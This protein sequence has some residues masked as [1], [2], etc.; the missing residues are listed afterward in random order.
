MN[1]NN[2]HAT[3]PLSMSAGI[4]TVR[5]YHLP[6]TL[7]ECNLKDEF[8][9]MFPRIG[10][11][12]CNLF[13]GETLCCKFLNYTEEQFYSNR[14]YITG[15]LSK[16]PLSF[17]MNNC[18]KGYA[19][20]I[21]PVVGYHLLKTPMTEL[22]DRQVMVSNVLDIEGHLLQ[23]LEKNE[24]IGSIDNKYL[25]RFLWESLPDKK[26][27]LNDPIYHAVNYIITNKGKVVI[28]KLAENFCV[29]QR[30]LQ[31]QFL[32]KVGLTPK[33]YANIWMTQH[34]IQLIG[35]HPTMSLAEVAFRV[36][37]YDVAHLA[38]D[39]KD[40]VALPPSTLAKQLNPLT[41][42]YLNAPEITE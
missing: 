24:N 40:R 9:N 7:I 28:K 33:A 5:E 8:L 36:G 3:F 15:L 1:G 27:F 21:H 17:S 37:Y 19:F 20:K 30:T 23:W 34:A 2:V 25:N 22:V 4:K 35:K 29:S 6:Y 11:L 12:V 42:S 10:H 13:I 26:S 31:R 41:S 32:M 38:H 14:L 39:F 16:G 18:G